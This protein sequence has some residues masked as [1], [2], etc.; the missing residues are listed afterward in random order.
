VDVAVVVNPDAGEA[1]RCKGISLKAFG[2]SD[3]SIGGM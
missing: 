2:E 3:Y 1:P